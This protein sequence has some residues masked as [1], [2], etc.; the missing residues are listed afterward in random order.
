ME[1]K[2]AFGKKSATESTTVPPAMLYA[3]LPPDVLCQC[4]GA[5]QRQRFQEGDEEGED[6]D[7]KEAREH[8]LDFRDAGARDGVL[9]EDLDELFPT[10]R[11]GCRA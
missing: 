4:L 7:S 11:G 6:S 9:E 2:E 1:I 8:N 5:L 10:L 3:G